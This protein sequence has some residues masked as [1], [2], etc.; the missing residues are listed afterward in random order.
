MKITMT[1]PGKQYHRDL[2]GLRQ[3][4]LKVGPGVIGLLGPRGAGKSTRQ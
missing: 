3:F 4:D 1:N 2:W